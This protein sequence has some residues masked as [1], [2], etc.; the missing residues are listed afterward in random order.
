[1]NFS[2]FNFNI[3][4]LN[5]LFY[6]YNSKKTN[7]EN[8]NIKSHDD[9]L[10]KIINIIFNNDRLLSIINYRLS[11][12]LI[13]NLILGSNNHIF[14][15]DKYNHIFY[16]KYI[17]ILNAINTIL[18]KSNSTKTRIY[19]NAYQ[20]FEESFILNKK[21][22]QNILNDF[23]INESF[24]LLFNINKNKNQENNFLNNIQN[25]KFS[26]IDFPTKE[27]ES[28]QCLFQL[29]TSLYDLK[30]L[31]KFEDNKNNIMNIDVNNKG[32]KILLRNI[33]FPL[34]LIDSNLNIGKTI[35]S[36][37]LKVDPVSII[38]KTNDI[39]Y[40]NYFIFTYLNYLFIVS[41]SNKNGENNNSFLIKD[42]IPLRQIVAYADRGEPRALYLLKE[43]N[44]SEITLFFDGVLRASSMKENIN[45]AIKVANVKEFSG[46][47]TFINNLKSI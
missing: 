33:E 27:Y 42:R 35:N 1:M 14:Y 8:I 26:I 45:N 23:F 5:K 29:L 24:Y 13:E 36:K 40:P 18:L 9:L 46:V 11:L 4:N 10:Q 28:L 39:E 41:Q 22:F 2:D 25:K 37:E 6:L 44:E 17:K 20:Y 31:L 12:E 47:K 38:Y 21:G 7:E 30:I 3:N 15:E 16:K 32:Q 43:E 19:K 34:Q